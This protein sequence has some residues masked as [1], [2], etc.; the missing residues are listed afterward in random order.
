MTPFFTA[1]I[2]LDSAAGRLVVCSTHAV[3]PRRTDTADHMK[4]LHPVPVLAALA[5][6]L[7][8]FAVLLAVLAVLFIATFW[9]MV[10]LMRLQAAAEYDMQEYHEDSEIS[11]VQ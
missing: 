6:L 10:Q 3:L 9:G 7:A 5:V 2:I 1:S 4:L 11:M 8:V